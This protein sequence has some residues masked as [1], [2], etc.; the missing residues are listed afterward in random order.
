MTTVV[1]KNEE[2]FDVYIGRGSPYGNPFGH[3][4]GTQARVICSSRA[5]A[6]ESYEKWVLGIIEVP[7][8][9]PPEIGDI[10]KH[11][12]SKVLGCFC[13]PKACHGDVLVKICEWDENEVEDNVRALRDKYAQD[14]EPEDL[15]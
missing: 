2:E 7:G 13:K 8:L 14:S 4:Q 1:N 6:I 10:R 3:R 15:F 9:Q 12:T 5:E 11:L